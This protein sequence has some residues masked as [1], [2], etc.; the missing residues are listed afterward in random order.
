M[1]ADEVRKTAS[2]MRAAS[3]VL[4]AFLGIRRRAAHESDIA[5]LR[6]AQVIIAGLIGAAVFVASLILLVRFIVGRIG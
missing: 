3:A 6:P 5:Q 1:T 4:W 2:P